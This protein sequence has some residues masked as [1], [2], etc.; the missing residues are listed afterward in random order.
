M[1]KVK[2][3]NVELKNPVA[4]FSDNIEMDI[5]FECME[6]IEADLDWELVFVGS[7][8]DSANDQV[9]ES[10]AVGPVKVGSNKFTL[11]APAPNINKIAAADLL[12]CTLLLLKCSYK[13]QLFVQVG[14]FVNNQYS[15]KELQENPPSEPVVEKLVRE[16]SSTPRVTTFPI[17]W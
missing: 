5:S 2:I 8:D 4:K 14:Y 17:D 16:L 10:V 7:S 1:S 3:A 6:Q 15:E 13:G 11:S 9:L 12:D